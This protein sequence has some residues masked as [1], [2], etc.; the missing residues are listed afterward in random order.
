MSLLL[1]QYWLAACTKST[2]AILHVRLSF[3]YVHQATSIQH[4][5][6]RRCMCS[7]N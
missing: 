4:V 5:L 1:V 6:A 3:Q 7:I 2:H